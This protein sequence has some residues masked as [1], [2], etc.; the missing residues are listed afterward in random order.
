MRLFEAATKPA[1]QRRMLFQADAHARRK[2]FT[3]ALSK[4][5]KNSQKIDGLSVRRGDTVRILRGDH[6]GFEGK[7]SR[8]DTRK[9]KVYVEG[10]TREKVDGTAIPVSVHPSKILI[11]HLN[12]DDKWRKKIVERRKLGLQQIKEGV[13]KPL[14]KAVSKPAKAAEQKAQAEPIQAIAAE[15]KPKIRRRRTPKPAKSKEEAAKQQG[16]PKPRQKRTKSKEPKKTE[17]ES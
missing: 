5:L 11:T 13:M 14:T 15:P 6:K 12:L 8:V 17:G 9:Y 3:A 16:E 2:F 7:V 4:E 10:L 1:K